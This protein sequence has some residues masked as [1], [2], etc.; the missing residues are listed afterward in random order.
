[1]L[2]LVIARLALLL[3]I[4]LA[5][6]WAGSARADTPLEPVP[7][8]EPKATEA[9]WQELVRKRARA[10]V[11]PAPEGC[12]P[13]RA[14]FYAATDWMRLTTKLAANASPCADYYVSV[15]PLAA[16]KTQP[17]ADQAWRI[18]ALGP[19]FHALAE[20]SWNGWSGW[21]SNTGSSWFAAGVEARRRIA[22]AGYDVALGDAW[23][24]NELSS[25]VRTGSG[26]ARANARE[27]LRGLY[28]GDGSVAPAR[29]VVFTAGINQSTSELSVYQA[30]LQDWL[31]DAAFWS[32]MAAYTSD[33][34]QEL[35]GDVRNYA[36][37]GAARAER[38]DALNEYLQHQLGLARA[39][40]AA[41]A[42]ARSFLDGAYSP[43]ANAAWRYDASFGWT[44]VSTELMQD[45][46][47]AQTYALRTARLPGAL[48]RFGFAWSPKNLSGLPAAEF[49]GQ[50]GALLDR[51]AAALH[52]S[53]VDAAGACSATWCAGDLGGS[54]FNHGWASFSTWSPSRLAFTSALQTL[55]AGAASTPLTVELQ[56]YSGV[57]LTAT[58]PLAIT[59]ASSAP[60]GHFAP[61]AAGPWTTTLT[62][63]VAPGAAST[64]FYYRDTSP[65]TPL[66]TAAAAGK[67][68]ARRALRVTR[69]FAA[70]GV[71]VWRPST[72][73]WY[74]LVGSAVQWGADGDVPVPA[75]YDGDGT[76]D[77]A[78][79]R[80]STGVW[81]VRGVGS[82]QW[83]SAEDVPVP[84]DYDDDGDTDIAVWR[85]ST[86]VWYVLG[87]RTHQWGAAGDV[88]LPGDYD[89]DPAL[90]LAV[91][92]PGTGTWYVQ[93]SL[94]VQWGEQLDVPVPADYDG[95]GKDEIA[96]WRPGDGVW[97]VRGGAWQQWGAAGDVPVPLDSDGDGA[98]ET[99]VW[100]PSNG[101]WYYGSSQW[102]W[103]GAGDVP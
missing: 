36:V 77:I 79:W 66:V 43:L 19:R 58:K 9:L 14:V 78:V 21:V 32:D 97:Y 99:A 81:W 55:S 61:G 12:R 8:L 82:W 98:V 47:S 75:D 67:E 13:L 34:S 44:D 76:V 54:W 84:A 3:G 103:G 62:V 29:G 85:P 68:S 39:G 73:V 41:A 74:P 18:R 5:L 80:P 2:L 4:G 91:W 89:A 63:E 87:Q 35:Y 45:Y 93:G 16:D 102:Q 90:D 28:T 7:S 24:L 53:E 70:L 48:D 83:G 20:I 1:M 94:I 10:P 101:F 71:A 96:V 26:S 72:G 50:S 22:A 59:L 6:V 56:T 57:T 92:R 69:P 100:R 30:R 95:D 17:R 86:G 60:T 37:P 23:A 64:S 15:P 27:F 42:E 65:G 40:P 25:A 49:A 52:D 51:L 31:E 11:A 88:A 33:W 46:V 38:R